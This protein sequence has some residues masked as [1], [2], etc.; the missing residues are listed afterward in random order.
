MTYSFY[1]GPQKP[2]FTPSGWDDIVSATADGILDETHW[3][4]LKKLLPPKSAGANTGLARDL[5]SLSVDGGA[6]VIGIEDN[7]GKPGAEV[8]SHRPRHL[9]ADGGKFGDRLR[10]DSGRAGRVEQLEQRREAGVAAEG[11]R[12]I[13]RNSGG[14][15]VAVDVCGQPGKGEDWTR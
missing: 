15:S 14:G 1:L 11:A 4:E 8:D 9:D 5:A 6:F 12:G 7:H 10:L 13:E 3:V 2:R